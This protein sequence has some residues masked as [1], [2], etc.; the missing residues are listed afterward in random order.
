MPPRK[1]Q[2]NAFVR[3]DLP[4]TRD[5]FTYLGIEEGPQTHLIFAWSPSGD[6]CNFWT[7]FVRAL[8][9]LVGPRNVQDYRLTVDQ[10]RSFAFILCPDH[11]DAEKLRGRYVT[12]GDTKFFFELVKSVVKMPFYDD[13]NQHLR[14]CNWIG[15]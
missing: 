12:V 3:H 9:R 4:M 15:D 5:N 1:F 11:V 2:P 10:D 8:E 13:T 6:L 7:L 14:A